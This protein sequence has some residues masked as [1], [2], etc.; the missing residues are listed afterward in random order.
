MPIVYSVSPL[1]QV[2][3]PSQL[4]HSTP[5]PQAGP[6]GHQLLVLVSIAT[7]LLPG[8]VSNDLLACVV[9]CSTWQAELGE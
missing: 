9:I 2:F 3:W 8:L 5:E 4:P 1:S 6:Q 7:P